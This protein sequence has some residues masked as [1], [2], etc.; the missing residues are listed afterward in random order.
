MVPQNWHENDIDKLFCR[1][2][3]IAVRHQTVWQVVAD[4]GATVAFSRQSAVFH[5]Q[6]V[7]IWHDQRRQFVESYVFRGPSGTMICSALSWIWW[8]LCGHL[9]EIVRNKFAG[10]HTT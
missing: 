4:A 5:N 8:V 2:C 10:V 9:G 6:S 3:P 7:V 1:Y